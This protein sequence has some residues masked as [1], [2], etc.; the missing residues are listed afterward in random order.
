MSQLLQITEEKS[1]IT[2]HQDCKAHIPFM[3]YSFSCEPSFVIAIKRF[4]NN[5]SVW[6][7]NSVLVTLQREQKMAQFIK[8]EFIL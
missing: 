2:I 1:K 3:T 6:T 7:A 4:V 8:Y 5:V